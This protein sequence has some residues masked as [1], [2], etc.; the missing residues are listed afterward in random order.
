MLSQYCSISNWPKGFTTASPVSK[1][2]WFSFFFPT[3][4]LTP[5]APDSTLWPLLHQQPDLVSLD[6]DTSLA[7]RK[8]NER[9]ADT[10]AAEMQEG[11]HIWVHDYH[12]ML[13]PLLLRQQAQ[14]RNISIRV[15]WFLH[16][17]FP[18]KDTFALLPSATQILEG[19][20]GADVVGFQ[21]DE[22]RHNFLSTSYQLLFVHP[23]CHCEPARD[24]TVDRG[25]HTLDK[26]L[27]WSGREISVGTF[28][29]G[30][31]P[32]QFRRRLRRE[33]VQQMVRKMRHRLQ[34]LKIIVGVDRLDVIKGVPHKLRAFEKML[35]RHPEWAGNVILIQLVIPSRANLE[36]NRKLRAEIQHVAASINDKYGTLVIMIHN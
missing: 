23:Q 31:E 32:S 2:I 27:L 21:T 29:V 34:G 13:L 30:V 7:Y 16:T 9:F 19:I 11:D 12:L 4:G 18:E 6:D 28:P 36:M 3:D 8:A 10:V 5:R 1:K 24:L 20:I 15:G 14:K 35:E 26:K 17:P 33:P 25:Q 22:A